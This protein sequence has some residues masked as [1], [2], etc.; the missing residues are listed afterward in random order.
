MFSIGLFADF[1]RTT[2]SNIHENINIPQLIKLVTMEINEP[3][4]KLK[5]H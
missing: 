2:Q 5:K 3:T 1:G 4:V